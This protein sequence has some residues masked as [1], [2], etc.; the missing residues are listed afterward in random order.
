MWWLFGIA[1]HTV[2]FA[3][4]TVHATSGNH[5]YYF[6]QAGQLVADRAPYLEI[7][8]STV[9][10]PCDIVVTCG[11]TEYSVP[12]SGP[13]GSDPGTQ[14]AHFTL[15]ELD[16]AHRT[17]VAGSCEHPW[18]VALGAPRGSLSARGAARIQGSWW[19][20]QYSLGWLQALAILAAGHR[21]GNLRHAAAAAAGATW[22]SK[23]HH[24]IAFARTPAAALVA[25]AQLVMVPIA[26]AAGPYPVTAALAA[27]GLA[28]LGVGGVLP[29][30]LTVAAA[31]VSWSRTK[32]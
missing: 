10:N 14:S 13:R 12:R 26:L 25:S 3:E 28:A 4:D 21:R 29:N 1:A 22:L 23:T 17:V 30:I 6:K 5:I 20:R 8:S 32:R 24:V 27:T 15:A 18:A 2:V 9:D 16:C 11:R 7:V 19:S 31:A